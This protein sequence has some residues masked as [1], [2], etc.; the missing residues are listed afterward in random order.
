MYT[1]QKQNKKKQLADKIYGESQIYIEQHPVV[2]NFKTITVEFESESQFEIYILFSF[3][4]KHNYSFS[5][6]NLIFI[7]NIKPTMKHLIK[8]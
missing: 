4:F 5:K 3:L 1:K 6:H 2:A 8:N 7:F